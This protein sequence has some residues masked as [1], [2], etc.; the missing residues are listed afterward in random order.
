MISLSIDGRAIGAQA[1]QSILSVAGE[2]NIGIPTL[3]YH[4]AL[5]PYGACRLCVV[6]VSLGGRNR[7]VTSCN[8]EV[9]EA[10]EVQTNSERV[11]RSRALTVELLLSRCPTVEILK[12]LAAEYGV[13]QPRFSTQDQEEKCI[14]CGLC[15]RIC[16]EKAGVGAVDFVGRGTDM[17]VAAP[18]QRRSEVCL[19]CGACA[20]V[21]PTGAVK[22]EEISEHEPIPQPSEFDMGVR[23]RS[24]IYI[25]YPQALPNVPVI[26]RENC[27]HFLNGGCKTCESFCPAGAIDYDQEDEIVEID[28]GAV[29][30][31]PGYC[32]FDAGQ[33]LETGFAWYPNV[34]SSLQF[35][36]L[37]SASGPYAGEI[38]RPS[39]LKTPHRIAFVQCVGSRDADRNYCSSVCCMYAT[40]E[41][42]IAKEH[43]QDLDIHIF[44]MDIRAFGKGFDLYYERA[45]E[46]GVVYTR[47]RPSS[48]EAVDSTG[49]LKIGYL[50]EQGAYASEDFDLVV[51]SSGIRPPREVQELAGR[52]GVQIDSQGFAVTSRF[53]PVES[54][55]PGVYVC[56][57]FSEPK[58]IPETVMEAS[59]AAA[60]AM[61]LLAEQRGTLV[62]EKQWPPEKK[63][64]G[65]LPRIGVFICHCGRNIAGV[66][67]VSEVSSYA[68]SLPNV[69]L[70]QDNLYTCSIDTQ[71]GIKKAID[72]HDLNRVVV[73]S[74]TP[75]THEPLFRETVREAG[76]NPYLFEMANIRDQCSWV[77]MGDPLRA[78]E[79]AK[80]LVRMA[81]AKARLLEPLHSQ[82]IPV[83]DSALVIGGGL[84][85]MT[86][87]VNLAEQGFAVHLVERQQQ[88]G[89][90]MRFLRT[91]LG[92]EDPQEQLRKTIERVN[93][94]A[95]ITVW[96]DAAV[97]SVS[98]FV[99]NFT[100]TIQQNGTRAEV[101]HGAVILATGAEELVPEEYGYGTDPRIVT[102]RE[103]E[104]MLADG[105]WAADRV[106]MVQCVGSREG[107]RMY[108]SRVCCSHSI[109][110][111]LTIK[112]KYPKT[113]VV[114]LYR[115]VRTYGFRERYYTLAREK[116]VRF[117][118][119]TV[120]N[121]PS[122]SLENGRIRVDAED[123]ILGK[124]LQIDC[125]LLA[126]AP[127][128]V[129]QKDAEHIAQMLKVPLTRERFFLEAHLKLRPVDF[130]VDG[131][132]L[133]GLAH[134]PKSVEETI[135][136]AQA[137]ASRAA[138]I[139][140]KKEYTPEAIISSA[141]ED[142]CAGCGI[143]AA[144]CYYDA[145]QIVTHRGR[146]VSRF[147]QALCKGCGA[148]AAAC[149]SGAVQQLGFRPK[150]ITDM[151]SAVLE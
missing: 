114:I 19:T 10:L 18:Y 67:N 7:I 61:A 80:D 117:V 66:V 8:Y 143:C 40:K 54:S 38:L 23:S 148:C 89:G 24:S 4:P 100:S 13:A 57:P 84:A 129:P 30:L 1:G 9:R 51:L 116:G 145:P 25:P 133:A 112:E 149:P 14:L 83:L 16:K 135:A 28:A 150:Q 87:A 136:Q 60:K 146:R 108:C 96:T 47:C 102:D 118:R 5:E 151:I 103:L 65:Q 11:R 2:H 74:C 55:A 15:V 36:R 109:K 29:I 68:E 39:D 124:P 33:K 130:S 119:Y 76:L 95:N 115:E 21:C 125:D 50:N 35:E 107:Q 88:L 140:S 138:T 144:V 121:K 85:G 62:V 134:A 110:N 45:K 73:A 131:V 17:R 132:F 147:N 53:R 142:V 64:A 101:E 94:L 56:G 32:L 120:E 137:T 12:K 59:G 81:V 78:T 42:I 70:A 127:A 106:V 20:Y 75:R 79:K 69:V 26:D 52:F 122:V 98:G 6:E 27:L 141:D 82:S 49:N 126:L 128:I 58:D 63:V 97:D 86:A 3:C 111:A 92:G 34:I 123:Q 93:E 72:E 41:A 44:Y 105:N 104:Q 91:L 43:E 46:L 99:G 139:I 77:H 31:S 71:S 90:N 22:L 113:D 37:L 48:V